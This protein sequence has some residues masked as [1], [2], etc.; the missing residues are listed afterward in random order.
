MRRGQESSD[1]NTPASEPTLYNAVLILF[2]STEYVIPITLVSKG[3]L[4][5]ILLNAS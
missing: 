1:V 2:S 4:D 3:K 5:P